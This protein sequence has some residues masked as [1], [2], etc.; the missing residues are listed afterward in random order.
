M[1][2]RRQAAVGYLTFLAARRIAKRVARRK[3][4]GLR[5]NVGDRLGR[6]GDKRSDATR[7]GAR[8][9]KKTKEVGR[10]GVGG[11]GSAAHAGVERTNALIELVRP[12]IVRAANDP[13]LHEALRNAF[14]TGREINAE[15]G[16]TPP[17][18]AAK[19]IAGNKKLQKRAVASATEL[20]D[21]LTGLVEEPRKR[22]RRRV[23]AVIVLIG[24]VAA[25]LPYLRKR[26]N[27]GDDLDMDGSGG[28]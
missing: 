12:I 27:G 19:K 15:V 3:L 13:Q 24:A 5:P 28:I 17:S 21:A 4:A 10:S 9:L 2:N 1:L 18:K 23:L 7:E 22:R 16:G 8:M 6:L 26:M 20:R 25:A 14:H 11:A